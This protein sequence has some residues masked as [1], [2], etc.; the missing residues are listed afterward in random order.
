M[1]GWISGLMCSNCGST[2]NDSYI[3]SSPVCAGL[4]GYPAGSRS[5]HGQTAMGYQVS[6]PREVTVFGG[7]MGLRGSGIVPRNQTRYRSLRGT[8]RSVRI[9]WWSSGQGRPLSGENI[10]SR[11]DL[12][13]PL[14]ARQSSPNVI[15]EGQL[16]RN[17][18][19]QVRHAHPSS[20]L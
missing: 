1:L 15:C 7:L 5:Q 3:D 2:V 17:A 12:L 16:P 8:S 13:T 18:V 19:R 14:I 9:C 6:H 20:A 10:A 4:R 11:M